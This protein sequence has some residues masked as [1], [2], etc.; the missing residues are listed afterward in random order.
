MFTET[1]MAFVEAGL[2]ALS[3]VTELLLEESV[4]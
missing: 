1:V 3:I 2:R 4:E